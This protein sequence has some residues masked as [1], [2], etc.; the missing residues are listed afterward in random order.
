MRHLRSESGGI[1]KALRPVAVPCFRLSIKRAMA[2]TALFALLFWYAQMTWRSQVYRQRAYA[3]AWS[4]ATDG[5]R[6]CSFYVDFDDQWCLFSRLKGCDGLLSQDVE[7]SARQAYHHR[8]YHK[9]LQA[10]S[11]PWFPVAADP[12]EQE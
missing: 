12:P 11:R 1:A 4:E 9:W 3:H 10:A 7:A 8:M 2:C 6:Y 5:G